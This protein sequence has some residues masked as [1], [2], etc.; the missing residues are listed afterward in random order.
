[1]VITGTFT[2][3]GTSSEVTISHGDLSISGTFS[4]TVEL[5]R[6]FG[7]NWVTV[8]TITAPTELVIEPGRGQTFRLECT[9]Y[10]SG[11]VTYAMG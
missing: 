3:T 7:G 1:M 10:T 2:A 9:A 8:E 5:Q 11:T 4:A 6:N